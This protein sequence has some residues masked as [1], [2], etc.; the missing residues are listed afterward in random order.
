[1]KTE[2]APRGNSHS[3]SKEKTTIGVYI[4]KILLEKARKHRLNI[5][6]I[7]EQALSSILDYLEAQNR[8]ESSKF[9]SKASFPKKVQG[10]GSSVRIEHHPPKV[11]VVGSN[12]T[13]PVGDKPRTVLEIQV[14]YFRFLKIL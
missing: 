2:K 3:D 7:T 5:S 11:G 12:P 13:P 8:S 4:N 10:A 14:Y 1:M 6:R 9:L